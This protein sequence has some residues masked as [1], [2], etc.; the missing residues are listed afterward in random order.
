M[1]GNSEHREK[2]RQADAAAL[3]RDG[4]EHLHHGRGTQAEACFREALQREPDN[5]LAMHR[6]GVVALLRGDAREAAGL[7]RRAVASSSDSA[8]LI[9]HLADALMACGEW[10]EAIGYW[11]RA[12]ECAP[13]FSSAYVKLG[14]A[15]YSKGDI[16]ASED[17][18]RKGIE[19]APDDPSA[20]IGLGRVLHFGGRYRDA[21][22][23]LHR[24]LE[25][26]HGSPR[27]C[28]QVGTVLLEAGGL[29]AAL[30]LFEAAARA[31]PDEPQAHASMGLALHWLGRVE[32]A[33]TSYERAL[34]I[35]PRNRLALKHLGVLYQERNQ[36]DAAA[37][38]FEKL[39]QVYPDDDVARHMLAATSGETTSGA[40]AGYVTR[41]YD[42]YADRFDEHL[43]SIDYR[44]PELIRDAIGEV[45]G[46]GD[47]TRRVLDLGCGTGLCGEVLRPIASTLAGIDLSPRMI[48]KADERRI[49]DSLTVGSMEEA[50]DGREP[51]FDLIV[52]GDVFICVG[53]LSDILSRCARALPAGGYVVF[54]VET[55]EGDSYRLLP[56]GRYAHSTT[57]IEKIAAVAGLSVAYRRDIVLRNDPAPIPGQIVVL[58]KAA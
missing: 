58:A 24:A 9:G 20:Y 2:H 17:A 19:I 36:L 4:D 28:M 38:C 39:L 13:D 7:L 3:I 57:Y 33:R 55:S 46:D 49:Y 25:L 40:P 54:S 5:P 52:A 23:A 48:A 42:D 21:E 37:A 50:L 26:G 16:E 51:V 6:S 44:V 56:T 47:V 35:D 41:L 31:E 12:L 34:S 1:N 14:D 32:D 53:D 45:I 15:C 29:D 43:G 27:V 10:D 30:E 18:Y 11:K 22:D 8:T